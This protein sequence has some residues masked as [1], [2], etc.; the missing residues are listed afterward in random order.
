MAFG[1]KSLGMVLG[2]GAFLVACAPP[3]PENQ[4]D[5]TFA[6][7]N[8]TAADD[9]NPDGQGRPSPVRVYLYALKAGAQFSTASPDALLGG[10]LGPLAE[11]MKRVGNF[12]LVAGKT[13]KR[14]LTLPDDTAEVG[15]AVGFRA[16]DTS[17]WRVSAPVT[18]NEV[19]LL[20][21]TIGAN[22]VTLSE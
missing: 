1:F 22:E 6:Q 20:K 17:K 4:P 19:T 21:A 14:R 11:Q 16:F 18:A 2:L 7:V 10:D 15:I 3:P 8:V 5:P 9:A 12:V 13:S